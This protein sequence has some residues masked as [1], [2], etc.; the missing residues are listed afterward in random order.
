MHVYDRPS[1]RSRI[2]I[3]LRSKRARAHSSRRLASVSIAFAERRSSAAIWRMAAMLWAS[4]ERVPP[5][6]CLATSLIYFRMTETCRARSIIS[7]SPDLQAA[8]SEVPFRPDD[9]RQFLA[10]TPD[11]ERLLVVGFQLDVIAVE[12]LQ[13]RRQLR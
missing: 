7:L 11:H 5:T 9:E 3:A 1:S 2:K 6:A 8:A 12:F 4:S 10:S 13:Q